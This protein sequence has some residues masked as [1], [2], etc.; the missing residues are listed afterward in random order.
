VK[1][2]KVWFFKLMPDCV[3]VC[4][5]FVNAP[6]VKRAKAVFLRRTKVKGWKIDDEYMF[7]EVIA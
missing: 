7:E 2:Y 4:F 1:K 5:T 6:D 3:D